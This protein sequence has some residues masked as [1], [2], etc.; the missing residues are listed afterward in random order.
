M[1]NPFLIGDKVYLRALER[2]DAP[3][4]LPWFN[5]PDILRFT[6]R[7]RPMNVQAEER[8]IEQ[9]SQ[10]EHDV[11]LLVVR[12][13]D[14]Q[15]IGVT[16]FYQLNFKNRNSLWGITI[17]DK[18]CWGRGYGTEATALMM[19]YGFETLNLHR[20]TLQVFADNPRAIH[21]Y[22]KLGFKKEG[23]MRQE[24]Y[25]DGRYGDTIVMGLLREEWVDSK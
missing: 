20:V 25:R 22:E 5:D 19:R 24:N 10:S 15:P 23:V 3:V 9:L 6:L 14:D 11:V 16:S 12:R 1:I 17:G 4:V 2:S 8:F 13:E 7:Y 21:I 18:T